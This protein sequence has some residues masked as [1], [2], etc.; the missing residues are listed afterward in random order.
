MN[1]SEEYLSVLPASTLL[2]QRESLPDTI[3]HKPEST[4]TI[5]DQTE[6]TAFPYNYIEKTRQRES[7]VQEHLA[8]KLREG[9]EL[10]IRPF[11]DDWILLLALAAAF[12]YSLIINLSKKDPH[13]FSRFFSLRGIGDP[14][15]RNTSELSNI[16]SLIINFISLSGFA[17]F[18]YCAAVR[19]GFIPTGM[20]GFLFWLIVL[21]IVIVAV[22]ARHIACSITGNISDERDLFNEYIITVYQA[23]RYI[24]IISFFL[25]ILL[26]YTN[27]FPEKTIFITGLLSIGIIFLIRF[28]RLSLIFIKRKISILYLILYLCA[29]EFLPVL[30]ILKYFAGMI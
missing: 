22:I 3:M 19:Y 28:I 18:T 23:Y 29:L 21:T 9:E 16:P 5:P 25:V 11:H 20:S 7:A 4:I 13:D 15:S 14:A 30:V 27:I 12:L 1:I 6:P 26:S 17:L 24:G 2:Y 10:P 8:R